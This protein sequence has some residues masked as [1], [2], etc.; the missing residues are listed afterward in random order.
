M[1]GKP[2]K[3]TKRTSSKSSRKQLGPKAKTKF[4]ASI[5]TPLVSAEDVTATFKSTVTL[6]TY[7]A[8]ELEVLRRWNYR[9]AITGKSFRS[10][11]VPHPYLLVTA[12]R[13]REA[14]GPL[15]ASNFLPL[16]V[17]A[18]RAFESGLLVISD[19]FEIWTG[20][21]RIASFVEAV[22]SLEFLHLPDNPDFWPDR[23]QLKWH[24][25]LIL[26]MV[27]EKA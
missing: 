27:T 2:R 6:E 20:M 7:P 10:R 14:G 19:D 1:A 11:R 22:V 18:R 16:V 17:E 24:R 21:G 26:G 5:E 25:D 9:C 4:S 13:P 8:L 12:I 23:A 3:T 15:H